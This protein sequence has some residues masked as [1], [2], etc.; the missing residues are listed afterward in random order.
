MLEV[1]ISNFLSSFKIFRRIKGG[2]WYLIYNDAAS[3]QN[4]KG[5]KIWVDQ[6]AYQVAIDFFPALA[7]EKY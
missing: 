5:K 1:S 6:A 3:Y 7:E 4:N 2:S